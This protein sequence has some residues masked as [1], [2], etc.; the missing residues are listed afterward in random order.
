MKRINSQRSV[1]VKMRFLVLFLVCLFCLSV[2]S[3]ATVNYNAGYPRIQISDSIGTQ[4]ITQVYNSLVSQYG[5]ST[6]QTTML[7][8]T[9]PKVWE[10]KA[11][12]EINTPNANSFFINNTDVEVLRLG[13]YYSSQSMAAF[14]QIENISIVNWNLTSQQESTSDFKPVIK[15]YENIT[16][17]TFSAFKI[18]WGSEASPVSFKI[19]ED[20]TI[21]NTTQAL[22]VYGNNLTINRITIKDGSPSLGSGMQYSY[23]NDSTISN[24]NMINLSDNTNPGTG[25]YGLH[26]EGYNNILHDISINRVQWSGVAIAGGNWTIYNMNINNAGHNGFEMQGRDSTVENIT[27]RNSNQTGGNNFYIDGDDGIRF[28]SNITFTN[29]TGSNPSNENF[30]MG[31]KATNI[32]VQNAVFDGKGFSL[33]ATENVTLIN[34]T[35]QNGQFG[36]K[37]Y[38]WIGFYN[39]NNTVID[40]SF[41]QS[42]YR[43][44]W[45]DDGTNTRF[46]NTKYSTLV[47]NSGN[48]SKLYY[49]NVSS[50]ANNYIVAEPSSTNA[51]FVNGMGTISQGFFIDGSG[52]SELPNIDRTNTPV[53]TDYINIY[54]SG[55]EYFTWNITAYGNDSKTTGIYEYPDELIGTQTIYINGTVTHPYGFQKGITHNVNPNS[56]WYRS[57]PNVDNV[58]SISIALDSDS[59]RNLTSWDISPLNNSITI[60]TVSNSSIKISSTDATNQIYINQTCLTPSSS[61]DLK[62][63]G[64]TWSTTSSDSNGNISIL[65]NGGLNAHTF[66]YQ[67]AWQYNSTISYTNVGYTCNRNGC[68]VSSWSRNPLENDNQH[69][70]SIGGT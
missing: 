8:E 10:V 4:N 53:I 3:S 42:T 52:Y 29:I 41:S 2:V 25:A 20:I 68:A 45:H 67:L 15:I 44:I 64:I 57:N 35:H 34:I 62:R 55:Y 58:S 37:Q 49:I 19:F 18:Y 69:L 24:M 30:R 51:S 26:V 36:F 61:Y 33:I 54:G 31:I 63:N 23:I 48:Y 70:L 9:S 14:A 16:N 50:D 46:I 28:F 5:E 39:Y 22:N 59:N 66:N 13:K 27:I 47:F 7:N 17:V 11:Y 60:L 38:D 12:L 1:V 40:S 6:V 43:D 32:I 21:K 65:Y 56:T